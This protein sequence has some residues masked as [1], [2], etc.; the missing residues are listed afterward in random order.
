MATFQ[1]CPGV[2]DLEAPPW[3]CASVSPGEAF[4][5]LP[6]A[7]CPGPRTY[8]RGRHPSAAGARATRRAAAPAGWP[9][10]ARTRWRRCARR[11]RTRRAPSGSDT[12]R[13]RTPGSPR[14]ARRGGGRR[15]RPRRRRTPGSSCRGRAR[16]RRGSGG[17]GTATR[18]S[19]RGRAP[20]GAPG[21]APARPARPGAAPAPAWR[22]GR[23]RAAAR[24]TGRGPAGTRRPRRG[25]GPG[26]C[27][28]A[29]DGRAATGAGG[30]GGRVP[31]PQGH[32]RG[33][34]TAEAPLPS[35]LLGSPSPGGGPGAFKGKPGPAPAGRGGPAS[36][37]APPPPPLAPRPAFPAWTHPAAA[38]LGLVWEPRDG[39][40]GDLEGGGGSHGEAEPPGSRSQAPLE[41][42]SRVPAT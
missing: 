9:P 13:A 2:A 8:P 3:R 35:L 29:R 21:P 16:S 34:R 33:S 4:A 7:A 38:G 30:S 27:G 36:P 5:S 31:G 24:G 39:Q 37:P 26:A 15:A 41:S 42:L 18:R 14:T 23:R 12:R 32:D 17:S 10:A 11:C 28:A 40:A 22:R 20:P 25:R 1:L 6:P 19:A